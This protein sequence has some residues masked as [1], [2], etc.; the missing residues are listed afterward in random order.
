MGSPS[1]MTFQPYYCEEN[2]WRL[3]GHPYFGT[4]ERRVVFISNPMR[5]VAFAG[6]RAA[7]PGEWV[8]WDYHVIFLVKEH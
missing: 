3:C 2:A 4:R 8:I 7:P 1:E 6:Q 5:A